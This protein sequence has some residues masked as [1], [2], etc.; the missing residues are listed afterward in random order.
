MRR[1]YCCASAAPLRA[2]INVELDLSSKVSTPFSLRAFGRDKNGAE[3]GFYPTKWLEASSPQAILCPEQL[4]VARKSKRPACAPSA[5]FAAEW[6][7]TR[8]ATAPQ[9]AERVKFVV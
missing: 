7:S 2:Q 3:R 8:G 1:P 6:L 9:R 5:I 4:A